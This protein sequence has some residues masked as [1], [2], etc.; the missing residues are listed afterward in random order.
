MC[1]LTISGCVVA[2]SGCVVAISGC[3][4]CNIWEC[5]GQYLGMLVAVSVIVVENIW[6][7]LWQY[8]GFRWQYICE[9]VA[10]SWCVGCNIGVCWEKYLGVSLAI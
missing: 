9:W 2:I 4:V 10:I 6:V 3:K 5:G 8:L 1:V 7:S